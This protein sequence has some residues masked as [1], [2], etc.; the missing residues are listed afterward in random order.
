MSTPRNRANKYFYLA[1]VDPMNFRTPLFAASCHS[2]KRFMHKLTIICKFLRPTAA[3]I[4]PL[5][6]MMHTPHPGSQTNKFSF[7]PH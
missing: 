1:L 6:D 4:F 3:I 7:P 5:L 2:K